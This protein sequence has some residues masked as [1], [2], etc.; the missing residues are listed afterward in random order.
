[1]CSLPCR[2]ATSAD[3]AIYWQCPSH[4]SKLLIRRP[5]LLGLERTMACFPSP[6]NNVCSQTAKH[7]NQTLPFC[8]R[9]LSIFSWIIR[10]STT[11]KIFSLSHSTGPPPKSWLLAQQRNSPSPGTRRK[12]SLPLIVN[13]G[14]VPVPRTR[15][16]GGGDRD[17]A[18]FAVRNSSRHQPRARQL[19]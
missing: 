10:R 11:G 9:S 4:N 3:F 15:A 8:V 13:S 16:T 17:R 2:Y 6:R 19:A 7:R 12:A 18:K 14:T 5:C 1:M